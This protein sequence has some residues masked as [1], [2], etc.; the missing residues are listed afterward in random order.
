VFDELGSLVAPHE[1]IWNAI[2]LDLFAPA[3]QPAGEHPPTIVYAGKLVTEKRVDVLIRSL[4]EIRRTVPEATLAIAGHGDQQQGLQ[5]QARQ[6]GVADH[7]R[8]VGTLGK[9]DLAQMF[10]RSD[11]FVSMSN[12][13][14]QSISQMQAMASGLPVVCAS[15]KEPPQVMQS[16]EFGVV[17]IEPEAAGRFT[18]SVTHLLT[19]PDERQNLAHRAVEAIASCSIPAIAAR[20]EDCYTHVSEHRA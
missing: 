1:V 5:L 19:H 18:E 16:P 12:S 9:S 7:V 3:G 4:R 15:P 8:F 13:E 20:W 11:I 10:R 14:V 17:P 6:L 2:D